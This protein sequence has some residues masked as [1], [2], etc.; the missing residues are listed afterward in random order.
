MTVVSTKRPFEIKGWHVLAV[1]IAAF[2]L[3]IAVNVAFAVIAVSTFPGEDVRRSY[4]QGVRYNDTLAARRVQ[5][6]LG[7]RAAAQ[8]SPRGSG[9][10]LIVTLTDS[11]G[12]PLD[13]ALIAGELRWPTDS[14][15]DRALAFEQVGAGR[16]AAHIDG[17]RP[18]LWRLRARGERGPHALDFEAEL[19]WPTS[20]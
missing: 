3:V 8:L 19:Q 1:M 12:L 5:A 20:R 17:L 2:G 18:G 15:F 14:R 7:W 6:A 13:D 4:L 9:V 11:N 10:D 16:Y